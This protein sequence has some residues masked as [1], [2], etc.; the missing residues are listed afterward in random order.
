MLHHSAEVPGQCSRLLNR[1]QPAPCTG[2]DAL[3][4]IGN[5]GIGQRRIAPAIRVAL[6]RECIPV[7]PAPENG[8]K[9]LLDDAAS[10]RHVTG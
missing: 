8:R 6:A 3:S 2:F 7:H 10:P 4:Q 9:C 5:L 1:A